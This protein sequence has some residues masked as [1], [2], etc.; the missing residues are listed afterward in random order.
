[1]N[2][3]FSYENKLLL[4]MFCTKNNLLIP[5]WAAVVTANTTSG[6]GAAGGAKT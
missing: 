6:L 3:P 1:M 5:S 4:G 2:I